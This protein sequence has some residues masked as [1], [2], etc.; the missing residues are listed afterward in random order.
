[1]SARLMS[2]I[3]CLK[4]TYVPK[5]IQIILGNLKDSHVLKSTDVCLIEAEEFL[6]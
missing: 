3:V 2:V 5:I 6:R 4:H 1:M